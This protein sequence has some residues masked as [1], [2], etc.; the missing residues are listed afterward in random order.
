MI[1]HT[2]DLSAWKHHHD[3]CGDFTAAM[4]DEPKLFSQFDD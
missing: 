2:L 3:Y 4:P 1:M